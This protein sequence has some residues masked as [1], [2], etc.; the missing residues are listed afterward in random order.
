MKLSLDGHKLLYH[1]DVVNNWFRGEKIYPIYC[2]I[3]LTQICNYRCIFCVYDSLKR[4]EIYLD[5]ERILS[6]IKELH[7]NGLKALFIS[8]EGEPLIHPNATEIINESKNYGVDCGL[9]TNG[10]FL[11]ED[12]SR[13]ILKDLTF[14]RVS[15]NGCSAENYSVIHRAPSGAY[16]KTLEN[17][18]HAVKLK[19]ENNLK[20]T[21]GAQCI[22]LGE[23]I[24]LIDKLT[25]D[26]KK[27]GI[28]YL[29]FKPFLTIDST[30]YRTKIDSSN[31]KTIEC[32]KE[33]ERISDDNFKVVVRW[34]SLNKLNMRTYDKCLSLPFMIEVD[35]HGD[36][37]PCGA[38]VGRKGYSYG[39]IY[40]H[41]YIELMESKKYKS[42]MEKIYNELNVHK[43][44]SNCRNDA[45]NRFLWELKHPPEHVN[46]I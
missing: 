5:S 42:V 31:N 28:D 46:F 22:I 41:S 39:N 1:L 30:K 17:L 14:I 29:A 27:I 3:S 9:N 19:K 16:G 40:R 23:N 8:G 6:I 34:D 25:Y 18:R 4:K 35:C 38:L 44:M 12:V 11:T 21:I 33:C 45:V 13:K 2:A 7:D 26:L 24:E 32:L 36:V 15:I 37:Y 10:F 43:C 20:V